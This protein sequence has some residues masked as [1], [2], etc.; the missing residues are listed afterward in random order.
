[1][2]Q[3]Q[4]EQK[5][6]PTWLLDP[7]PPQ[8]QLENIVGILELEESMDKRVSTKFPQIESSSCFQQLCRNSIKEAEFLEDAIEAL[9]E[10]F[11]GLEKKFDDFEELILPL[12]TEED[13]AEEVMVIETVL[14][15]TTH[16]V[17]CVFNGSD[18]F[19]LI[20]SAFREMN[21]D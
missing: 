13:D 21:N 5:N 1:M 7:R 17:V 4:A 15:F 10:E 14:Q 8:I 6:E 3:N 2:I 11:E 9:G 20:Y 12:S 16:A 19:S 18:S